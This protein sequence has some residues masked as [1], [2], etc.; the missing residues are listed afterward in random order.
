VRVTRGSVLTGRDGNEAPK[1]PWLPG[2]RSHFDRPDWRKCS[3]QPDCGCVCLG[4]A[5]V[6]L[7][8]ARE[9]EERGDQKQTH[10]GLVA[11]LALKPFGIF[12]HQLSVGDG[13]ELRGY[14]RHA[15][16]NTFSCYLPPL[17]CVDVSET[18]QPQPQVPSFQCVGEPSYRHIEKARESFQLSSCSQKLVG[19]QGNRADIRLNNCH[20]PPLTRSGPS[21]PLVGEE[22]SSTTPAPGV[23]IPDTWQQSD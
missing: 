16:E 1:W 13:K 19:I 12:P 17:Q 7:P 9:P 20:R 5:C 21:A 14:A 3:E 2:G 15:L 18:P 22:I 6:S 23:S 4:E 10:E 8:E 11:E